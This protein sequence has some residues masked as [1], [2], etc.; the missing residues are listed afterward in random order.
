MDRFGAVYR[1]LNFYFNNSASAVGFKSSYGSFVAALH[2][3]SASNVLE[4]P[5]TD[6]MLSNIKRYRMIDTVLHSL[7]TNSRR[8]LEACY[9][10]QYRYPIALTVIYGSKAGCSLF[11]SHTADL[12]QLVRL[13]NK[14]LLKG[15]SEAESKLSFSIGKETKDL[16][17]RINSEYLNTKRVVESALKQRVIH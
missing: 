15:L 1:D 14:K 8:A 17:D 11:N 4:D 9:N 7:P 16:W 12:D 13:A 5:Y 2:G 10:Q 6:G 3:A